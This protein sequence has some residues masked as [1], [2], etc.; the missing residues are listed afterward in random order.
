[1]DTVRD[2]EMPPWDYTL[3]HP[4]ARLSGSEKRELIEGLVATFEDEKKN[5]D[6][7]DRRDEPEDRKGEDE[8]DR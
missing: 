5:A 3:A 2:G 7:E 8:E 1:M 4:E 6:E